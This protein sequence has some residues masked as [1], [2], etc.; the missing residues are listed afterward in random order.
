MLGFVLIVSPQESSQEKG[1]LQCRKPP[2]KSPFKNRE[3]KK[4]SAGIV[5][6]PLVSMTNGF[7][8]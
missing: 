7:V 2:K 5:L 6:G 4:R 1:A 3:R 8:C